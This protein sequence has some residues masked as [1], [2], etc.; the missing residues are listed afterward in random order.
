[1]RRA[2]RSGSGNHTL[3]PTLSPIST[4]FTNS[5]L[6][7]TIP[8]PSCPPTSGSFVAKG[9]SP[10]K[11]CKSVW[12]TP[13]NLILTNT[14]SG[15]GFPTGICLYLQQFSLLVNWMSEGTWY[16][17]KRSETVSRKFV[18]F[19][20]ETTSFNSLNQLDWKDSSKM[21]LTQQVLLFSQRPEPIAL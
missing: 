9:Q 12:H 6:A 14:S 7:T 5:P 8:A 19:H 20:F 10:C 13:E 16:W 4:S 11:A 18:Y 15:P 17:F 21:L 1:M 3:I 2:S